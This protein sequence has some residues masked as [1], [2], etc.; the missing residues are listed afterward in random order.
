MQENFLAIAGRTPQHGL[1]F[2]NT[3]F[4]NSNHRRIPT[5]LASGPV[6]EIRLASR[7]IHSLLP[8]IRQSRRNHRGW[9]WRRC[10]RRPT[11]LPGRPVPVVRLA[12]CGVRHLLPARWQGCIV[13][14]KGESRR[15]QT[16][17]GS[18]NGRTVRRVAVTQTSGCGSEGTWN[19]ISGQRPVGTVR[20]TQSR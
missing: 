5:G 12:A 1:F 3:R 15:W 11:R 8:P 14:R 19:T 16:A 2:Y 13:S 4:F 18:W 6:E 17:V 7:R 10:R 9:K 20:S